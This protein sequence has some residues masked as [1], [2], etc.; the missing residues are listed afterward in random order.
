MPSCPSPPSR[1]SPSHHHPLLQQQAAPS[2]TE[3]E[4]EALAKPGWQLGA[5]HAAGGGSLPRR[6]LLSCNPFLQPSQPACA[7][8]ADTASPEA[9]RVF[10][11]LSQSCCQPGKPMALAQ[12]RGPCP[13][14]PLLSCSVPPVPGMEGRSWQP[15]SRL[16]KR[17]I[18][19]P[20]ISL[21]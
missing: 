7:P 20:S 15:A 2:G 21:C 18:T 3:A 4:D 11:Q 9:P 16:T 14:R 17:L 12:H 5:P 19:H 13:T 1:G 10:F 8:P 6:V